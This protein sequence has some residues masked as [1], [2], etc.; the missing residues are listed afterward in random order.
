[1]TETS[2]NSGGGSTFS[3]A[4]E[5]LNAPSK[6]Y[7]D[8][9]KVGELRQNEFFRVLD[10]DIKKYKE[11]GRKL[12]LTLLIDGKKFTLFMSPTFLDESERQDA[13]Q[14]IL[15]SKDQTLWVSL[16]E[17]IEKKRKKKRMSIPKYMFECRKRT[18]EDDKIELQLTASSASVAA[19]KKTKTLA[20]ANEKVEKKKK[21]ADTK[22][23]HKKKTVIVPSSEDDDDDVSDDL[24]DDT[25]DDTDVEG[26]ELDDDD[27]EDQEDGESEVEVVAKKKQFK[28]QK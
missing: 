21:K 18:P 22:K 14:K 15:Q 7:K 17:I 8:F 27:D 12:T 11:F 24:D 2:G 25:D 3:K 9:I 19:G 20:T 1:M 26:L 5:T 4:L 16:T 28:K 23:S 6:K 10:F 13:F